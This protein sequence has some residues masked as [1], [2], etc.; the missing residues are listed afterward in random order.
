MKKLISILLI[1]CLSSIVGYGQDM[2]T[3]FDLYQ[4]NQIDQAYSILDSLKF[5]ELDSCDVLEYVMVKS[6]R[7][8]INGKVKKG[9]RYLKYI[10]PKISFCQ[11][12]DAYK[13][14][15]QK[16]YFASYADHIEVAMGMEDK[17]NGK[18]NVISDTSSTGIKRLHLKAKIAKHFGK[19]EACRVLINKAIEIQLYLQKMDH[20]ESSGFLRTMAHSYLEEGQFEKAREYFRI[21]RQIYRKHKVLFPKLLGVMFYNEANTHYEQLEFNEAIQ[22]YDS[23]LFYWAI[24]APSKVYLRYVNE[25]LGDLYYETNNMELAS[26]YWSKASEI[27]SPK[28]NDKVDHLPDIKSAYSIGDMDAVSKA[29]LDALD[30]RKTTYGN[31]HLLTGE[32][33]TFVGRLS[34]MQNQTRKALSIYNQSLGILIPGFNLFRNELPRDSFLQIDRYGFDAL[35]GI[36]RIYYKMYL[37]TSDIAMLDSAYTISQFAFDALDKVKISFEDSHTALFWSDFTYPLTELS[38]N[39]L[40]TL[41]EI[42]P[43]REFAETAFLNAEASRGYMLRN[44]LHKDKVLRNGKLPKKIKNKEQQLKGTLH[45]LKGSIKMEEK[46]CG[47]AQEMKI[48]V[49]QEELV[50]VQHEYASFLAKMAILHPKYYKSMYE[51]PSLQVDELLKDLKTREKGF[52][53]FFYGEESIFRFYSVGNKIEFNKIPLDVEFE[54]LI[55]KFI[56]Q[57][58]GYKVD[59]KLLSNST[60]LYNRLFSETNFANISSLVIVPDGPLN[61]IPWEVLNTSQASSTTAVYLIEKFPI[62]YT[63]SMTLVQ[64]YFISK[65]RKVDRLLSI[66]PEYDV[67]LT[68]SAN[69]TG[70]NF[71]RIKNTILKEKNVTKKSL[72]TTAS[73][74]DIIHFAGHSI[75]NEDNEMMSELDLG[76]YEDD[77]LRS[78]EI[79]DMD[80]DASLVVLSSCNSGSGQYKRGEGIMNLSQ[81]F[82]QAGSESVIMSLW[83][84]DDQSTSEIFSTFYNE[85][86]EGKSKSSALRTAKL[87]MI[88]SGDP[89]TSHPFF[90]APFVLYGDDDPVSISKDRTW[91]WYGVF[92]GSLIVF[93][94]W[95]FIVN[96]ER[97]S[98]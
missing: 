20:P 44:T 51:T 60:D 93:L 78:H 2:R 62:T 63:Q 37:E 32:C 46:R 61:Y 15:V 73:N 34:E 87:S 18:S 31:N 50:K 3:C 91:F 90:W 58:S 35:L 12:D 92:G 54:Q 33:M 41:Q 74:A 48:K 47:D 49:W 5:D 27:K 45:R 86:I 70:V 80:L 77:P 82:Q 84:V 76:N 11:P 97:K 65:P 40:F 81:A 98:S 68:F 69:D 72:I 19:K 75:I 67:P 23:T 28:S 21:E 6:D 89:I 96:K 7:Y 13:F 43:L 36:T 94:F 64:D 25:A 9:Y 55:A 88:H 52:I 79:F 39:I 53:S 83:S 4:N 29:Y 14:L 56:N 85:L 22:D 71:E 24:E 26:S 17:F 1:H 8:R 42:Y 16:A 10:E 30:F 95:F 59:Q 66:Y 38:L 57:L